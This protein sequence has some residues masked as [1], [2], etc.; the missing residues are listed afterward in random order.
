MSGWADIGRRLNQAVVKLQRKKTVVVVD[1]YAGTFE[2]DILAELA[3]QLKPAVAIGAWEALCGEDEINRLCAPFLGGDDPLFG[4][5]SDLE[6]QRFFDVGKLEAM[7][8]R[9]S[10]ATEGS[11]LIV[12]VGARFVHDG[13]LVIYADMPR[14][15]AQRRQRR[16]LIGNLGVA[17]HNESP[18]LKYK[19]SFF[20][21]WR[22]CDRWKTPILD[23]MD[24]LLDTTRTDDPKLATGSAVRR[25]MEETVR[26]PFRLVPFFDPGPWGGQWM[27][28]V[29]DLDR[30]SVN[31]AWCFDCVPEENSLLL[32]IGEHR[33]EIP[34]INLVLRHPRELLGEH[35]HA[36]F[37][38]E[39]P[40]RFDLL[41]TM[42]GGNLSLQVHP[43]DGFIREKFGMKYT[44][45]ESYY[46]LDAGAD[47][48]V[49][50]G[51]KEGFDREAFV[52]DLKAAQ[53]GGK[54]F[55]PSSCVAQ[56]P[57]GKHDHFL[58]PA[59]TIHCS[60]ANCM[61]LEI[62][63]TPYIFTFKLWDWNRLGMDGKP[64]PINIERGMENLQW[65]R[66]ADI[67]KKK[68]INRIEL[69]AEGDGWREES[70]GLHEK[71]FIETRRH[72]FSKKVHH[73]AGGGVNVLN[74]IEGNEVVVESPTNAFP[75]FTVHYAETFVVPAAVGPYTIRPGK[76]GK[77][78]TIKAR[79]RS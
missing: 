7:R 38:A 12:G 67:V 61:V 37:G 14:W 16:N 59:G 23:R 6:L 1:C 10:G 34:S 48:K 45:D 76:N 44:Q 21:D 50:L 35:V 4:R 54:E 41:D 17:N 27:K 8:S 73:D 52:A 58:I 47:A 56:W 2:R 55:E 20:I 39:F 9:V 66:T 25:G 5:M 28:E 42:G 49:W 46:M 3:R 78:A 29:C 68:F 26:R 11:I 13:D 30:T 15:E 75:P 53:H 32:G 51:F 60:G 22:V 36:R 31:F 65:D 24:F 19:R 33:V 69:I 70:T 77:Y 40:I 79:V 62:S 64:R 63:A 72:W 57:A 71:G 43:L 18:G 74:L